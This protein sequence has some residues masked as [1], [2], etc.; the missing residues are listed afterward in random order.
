MDVQHLK[1]SESMHGICNKSGYTL[2]E[3]M[4]AMLVIGLIASILSPSLFTRRIPRYERD[5][6]VARLNSLVSTAVQQSILERAVHSIEFDFKKR[7]AALKRAPYSGAKADDFESVQGL[8]SAGYYEWPEQFSIKQFIVEGKDLMKS[9]AR[10]E[11]G[12]AWF[13]IVPEGLTQEVTINFIDTN[14][15]IEGEA[16]KVGLVLNPFTAQFKVYENFQK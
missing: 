3:L 14:D 13:F 10:K 12:E 7:I 5:Q 15:T 1:M 11:T 9:F 8:G 16:R 2:L 4:V 6:F